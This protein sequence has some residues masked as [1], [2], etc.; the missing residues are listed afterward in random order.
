MT[1]YS[2]APVVSKKSLNYILKSKDLVKRFNQ[3]LRII[4]H[5]G[6]YQEYFRQFEQGHYK[7]LK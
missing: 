5:N 4:K 3:Q 7:I 6:R 1:A 2:G